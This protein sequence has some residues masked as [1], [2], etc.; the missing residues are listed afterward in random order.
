MLARS[1]LTL[2]V[3]L[4]A[5]MG[6]KD[7]RPTP[8]PVQV[9][10][11]A[12]RVEV[13]VSLAVKGGDVEAARQV[14]RR[15]FEALA[16]DKGSRLVES[17]VRHRGDLLVVHAVFEGGARCGDANQGALKELVTRHASRSGRLAFHLV[18]PRERR[19]DLVRALQPLSATLPADGY[20][21]FAGAYVP[22]LPH[23]K[24]VQRLADLPAPNGYRML[25]ERPG[26]NRWRAK[27]EQDAGIM[28]YLLLEK[29]DLTGRDVATA[30]V[31]FDGNTSEPYVSL[32]FTAEGGQ[33][34]ATVT[35]AAV[36][37]Y[38]AIVFEGEVYSA[39]VIQEKIS[40]GRARITLGR[41]GGPTK[42]LQQARDMVIMLQAGP[43]ES[44]LTVEGINQM[45]TDP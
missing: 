40:G 18:A 17:S 29:P 33:R 23:D 31:V 28:V 44:S 1:V 20:G 24:V 11:S 7:D 30:E 2:M 34:F 32:D 35:E 4:L 6:C 36:K 10:R 43:L 3:V 27:K 37:R 9:A 26:E 38:L 45:C 8:Q 16:K 19:D 25:P 21:N 41:V 22:K 13:E 42:L 14:L 39:P 12:A 5:L 15:R